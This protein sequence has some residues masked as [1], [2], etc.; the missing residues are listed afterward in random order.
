MNYHRRAQFRKDQNRNRKPPRRGDL[1]PS[2]R[3][4]E[5]SFKSLAGVQEP[6]TLKTTTNPKFPRGLLRT[7]NSGSPE[8]QR[9][10]RLICDPRSC[11]QHGGPT[12]RQAGAG[13]LL[14]IL[15][16]RSP[17]SSQ[18]CQRSS[19]MPL[20]VRAVRSCLRAKQAGA[21]LLGHGH[22]GRCSSSFQNHAQ[23]GHPHQGP[24]GTTRFARAAMVRARWWQQVNSWPSPAPAQQRHQPGMVAN[25]G[26]ISTLGLCARRDELAQ[27][28]GG[29]VGGG[30]QFSVSRAF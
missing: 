8:C 10:R 16:P 9:L 6:T 24:A 22:N 30:W 17:S 25:Y 27:G 20:A 3:P 28:V 26:A 15:T 11:S 21:F 12:G 13:H 7:L 2:P 18:P 1:R 19:S 14:R 29:G 5:D 23:I 4:L